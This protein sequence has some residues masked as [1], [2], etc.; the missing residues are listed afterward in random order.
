MTYQIIV[1][2]VSGCGKSTLGQAI[3]ERI[4]AEFIDG[5]DLHP[6]DNLAKMKAGQPL[7]DQDREPW[8]KVI[9]HKLADA[10]DSGQG[11]VIACSALKRKY[12]DQIRSI[13]PTAFF[14]HP[15]GSRIVLLERL[16]KRTG[17]FMPVS[18]LDSQLA[19]L[20]L[21]E[22][23]EAGIQLSMG[24]SVTDQVQAVIR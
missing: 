1:M 23:D 17:H 24:Q 4:G 18:L 8:L 14:V 10:A 16:S 22:A 6:V 11:L 9:G 15:H 19:D 12:R 3:A 13:S 20:E 5:D 21:L 2:G 7:N